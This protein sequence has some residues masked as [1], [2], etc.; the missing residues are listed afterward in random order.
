MFIFLM[1]FI[2]YILSEKNFLILRRLWSTLLLY[3]FVGH[4]VLMFI[5]FNRCHARKIVLM[6]IK[7]PKF[8]QWDTGENRSKWKACSWTCIWCSGYGGHIY[9]RTDH[10][11]QNTKWESL[12]SSYCINWAIQQVQLLGLNWIY[13]LAL[14]VWDS[15]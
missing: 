10:W 4:V 2:R 15:Y 9:G 7:D 6:A 13:E 5:Y 14:F 11:W 8:F 3:F 12:F 1:E